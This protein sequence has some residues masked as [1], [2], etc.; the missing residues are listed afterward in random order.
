MKPT[1]GITM[2]DPTGVGPE[3]TL[4]AISSPKIRRLCNPVVFGDEGIL[5]FSI[6]NFQFSISNLKVIN[7]SHLNPR[8]LKPG[9]PDIACARAVISYIKKGVEMALAGKLDAIVT[10]PINKEAINRAGF[11]FPGHTEFLAHLTKTKD[12]AMMLYGKT[13]KVVVVTIHEP[14]KRVPHLLTMETVF[15]TIK[16][17]DE[18][19]RRYFG[20]NRPR[21]A[22]AGLNPHAGEGGLFGDEEKGII[23][24]AIK[25]ARRLGIDASGPHPP[26]TVFYR[27]VKGNEFDAV[28]CMYH[29]QGLIPF[30]LLHFDDG[31]N[32]TLGLPIVRT[33]VDHGT[34]YDIAWKGVANPR[35]MIAAIEMAVEMVRRKVER[36]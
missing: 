21:I 13:L 29:D 35:S 30:K 18:G 2:G 4:K 6:S 14:I 5:K 1:I 15:D 28:V 10:G 32:V 20:L 31:V 3:I 23:L 17:T 19:L 9:K 27:V 24:L 7:L 33:S 26:D 22:V 12:Y 25:K 8:R 34:G 36:R 11:K 16:I